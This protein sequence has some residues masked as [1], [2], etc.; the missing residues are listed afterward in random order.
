MIYLAN[1]FRQILPRGLSLAIF[2]ESKLHLDDVQD[3]GLP[4]ILDSFTRK[5]RYVVWYISTIAL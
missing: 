3:S 2:K 5:L 4:L 1:R